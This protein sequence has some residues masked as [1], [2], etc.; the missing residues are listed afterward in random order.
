MWLS[1]VKAIA[2]IPHKN[3]FGN[4]VIS[5][6]THALRGFKAN[7]SSRSVASRRDK[8]SVI[9]ILE[10]VH[11]LGTKAQAQTLILK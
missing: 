1:L 5:R 11:T 3:T 9:Y 8:L 2:G 7:N 10:R 4:Y 6:S